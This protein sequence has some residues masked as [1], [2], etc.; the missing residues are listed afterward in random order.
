MNFER[1]FGDV[2][3][4][5]AVFK[6]CYARKL[7]HFDGQVSLALRLKEALHLFGS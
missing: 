7:K 4:C 5:R 2:D 1:E 6:R 3:S